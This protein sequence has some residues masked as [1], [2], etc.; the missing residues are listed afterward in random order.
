MS[1]EIEVR[2]RRGSRSLL[3]HE[4]EEVNLSGV[5]SF[6]ARVPFRNNERHLIRSLGLYYSGSAAFS[7]W[8]VRLVLLS[9]C[10]RG[11]LQKIVIPT[12]TAINQN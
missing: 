3:V 11:K 7:W 1:G 9:D 5:H 12:I 8:P 4:L 2:H 10:A 6:I